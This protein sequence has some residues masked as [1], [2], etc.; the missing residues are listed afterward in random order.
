MDFLAADKPLTKV[1]RPTSVTAYP[2]VKQF[3]SCHEAVTNIHEAHKAILAHAAQGHCLLKGVLMKEL[4]DESRRESTSPDDRTGWLCLDFDGLETPETSG[5]DAVLATLGLGDISYVLQYSASQGLKPGLYA[6]VFLFLDAPAHPASLKAWLQLQNL[7]CFENQL[8]LNSANMNLHWPLDITACQNDKL[9]YIAPPVFEGVDD[10]VPQRILFAARAR[11]TAHLESVDPAQVKS[12][13]VAFINRLRNAKGLPPRRCATRMVD[14]VLVETSPDTCYVSGIK[15][16]HEF[17]RLNL[18]GGD[19]WAYWHP[20]NNIEYLHDFKTDTIWRTKQIV[21]EYYARNKQK[22]EPALQKEGVI[23]LGFRNLPDG[24]YYNALYENKV[25]SI[26]P[27]KDKTRMNDFV[28]KRGFEP[29]RLVDE[30]TITYEPHSTI[31]FDPEKHLLNTFVGTPYLEATPREGNFPVIQELICHF[32]ACAPPDPLYAHFLNWLAAVFQHS[33]KPHTAWV[34]HGVEGTGKGVFFEQVLTPLFGKSNCFALNTK[35]LN[36]NF[37]AW[38]KNKLIIFCDEVDS[39]DF[40]QKGRIAALLRNLITENTISVRDMRT[41]ACNK[42]NYASFFFA[43]NRPLPVVVPQHDRRYNVG[44]FQKEKYHF[45]GEEAIQKD[46]MPFAQHLRAYKVN[47]LAANTPLQTETRTNMQ[48]LTR[49]SID[50]VCQNILNGDFEELWLMMPDKT[51]LN[52]RVFNDA[53]SQHAVRYVDLMENILE[54]RRPKLTRDEI[55]VI[56][57][58]TVGTVPNTPKKLTSFLRHHG[59]TTKRI[60]LAYNTTYG[61]DVNWRIPPNLKKTN[62]L[63]RVK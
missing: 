13:T 18:N 34:L 60:R 2:M 39:D 22:A 37:N 27:A 5:V 7:A 57:Q 58:H 35:T 36:D 32:L 45:P 51:L 16:D 17:T 30:W 28:A 47:K 33:F 4:N 50:E 14:G 24:N 56:L 61:I 26:Y 46:L 63:R 38:V 20:K 41:T 55:G 1:I 52:N 62:P 6:H 25:L 9:L 59:I 31:I 10:P 49:T 40:E 15:E 3:T 21:P 53:F 54:T 44:N 8:A 11:Q 12:R 19:S 42:T 43:S 48:M 29:N 23:A